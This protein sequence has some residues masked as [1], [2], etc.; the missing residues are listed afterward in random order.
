M[1]NNQNH[2][3]QMIEHF[4]DVYAWRLDYAVIFNRIDAFMQRLYDMLEICHAMT[5]FAK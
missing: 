4:Q 3:L 5:I 1:N 2:S